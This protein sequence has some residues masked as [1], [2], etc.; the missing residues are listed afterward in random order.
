M[1]VINQ[2]KYTSL[3]ELNAILKLYNVT[4][5]RGSEDSRMFQQKG[6]TYRVLDEGGNKIGTP[7]KASAFFM[8]PTL[9]NLEKKF[10]ENE[11]LR[12]PFRKRLQTNIGWIL[13]KEPGSL[14]SFVR[15]LE[16]ENI[17]AISRKGKDGVIYGISYVD[18]KMK[19]VFNGSDLGK[20]YSAKAILDKCSGRNQLKQED[21]EDK[22]VKAER[23]PLLQKKYKG[24]QQE[25]QEKAGKLLESLTSPSRF[26]DYVPQQLLKKKKRKKKRLSI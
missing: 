19:S 21:L 2:Y 4:A 25:A 7:I 23:I 20:E 15:E 18:H 9:G 22:F 8:R 26:I 5:D 12:A 24:S 11:T 13:N 6:L 1:V 10:V 16:K 17:S 14:E 3:P